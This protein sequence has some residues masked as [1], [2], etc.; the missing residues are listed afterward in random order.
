[1][2]IAIYGFFAGAI[3]TLTAPIDV[4]MSPSLDVVGVRMGMLLFPWALGLLVGTPIAGTILGSPGSWQGLKV[5]VGVTLS[6]AGIL[7][8]AARISKHGAKIR[9]RC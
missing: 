6:V 3:T 1:M 9:V 7:C 8:I 5:F 4:L 2:F